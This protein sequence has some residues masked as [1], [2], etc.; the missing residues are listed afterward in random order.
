[1]TPT[2]DEIIR[3]ARQ[4][5]AIAAGIT[6]ASPVGQDQQQ[7]FDRWLAQG[8]E[9]EL[10]YMRRH[11]ELRQNP[12]SLLP[13][14][15]TIICT[16]FSYRQPA[17]RHADLPAISAYALGEDY[18]ITLR[19]RLQPICRLLADAGAETRICTDSAPLHER[20]LAARA[21]LGTVTLNGALSVPL[22][23]SKI[24]LAEILTTAE[25]SPQKASVAATEPFSCKECLRCIRACPTQAITTDGIDA[26][27]CLSAITIEHRGPHTPAQLRLLADA[28]SRGHTLPLYGC[29]ICRDVCPRN[30]PPLAPHAAPALPEFHPSEAIA[31]LSDPLL[32][33]MTGGEFKRRFSTSPLLRLGLR[34]LRRNLASATDPSGALN[35]TTE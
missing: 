19:R 29:D 34:D 15:R 28:A 21:G 32:S 2:A 35:Q 1:M 6:D 27:R 30:H 17:L 9:G 11:A 23:G 24:F 18:H 22:H 26:S 7:R 12:E 31:T 10:A 16:A 13:G 14:A 8:M 20:Y 5:G 25:I 3:L 33:Q 4:C